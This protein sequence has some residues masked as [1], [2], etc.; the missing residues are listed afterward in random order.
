[1]NTLSLFLVQQ[2]SKFL[3]GAFA[4]LHFLQFH[5]NKGV[6]RYKEKTCK[7]MIGVERQ[8]QV[9]DFDISLA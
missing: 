8:H 2:A 6:G 7:L 9:K 4:K 1:V 5:Q 3:S